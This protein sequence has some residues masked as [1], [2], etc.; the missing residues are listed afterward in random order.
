MRAGGSSCYLIVTLAIYISVTAAPH[1]HLPRLPPSPHFCRG[2]ITRQPRRVGRQSH[3]PSRRLLRRPASACSQHRPGGRSAPAVPISPRCPHRP[4]LSPSAPAV[5]T[6]HRTEVKRLQRG[7]AQGEDRQA[8]LH[9]GSSLQPGGSGQPKPRPQ[10]GLSPHT[11]SLNQQEERGSAGC[12]TT[13]S[14]LDDASQN[15]EVNMAPAPWHAIVGP[16]WG[17][18]GW[19]TRRH[20]WVTVPSTHQAR[21]VSLGPEQHRAQHRLV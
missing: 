15:A 10:R 7:R 19:G 17:R 20:H 21:P 3:G 6:G 16:P 11:A 1:L 8:S 13:C 4:P 14:R 18:R 2:P 9:A 5:P 12:K